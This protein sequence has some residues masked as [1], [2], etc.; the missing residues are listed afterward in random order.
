MKESYVRSGTLEDMDLLTPY[1]HN[2]KNLDYLIASTEFMGM[3]P[4]ALEERF[5]DL[6][7][8]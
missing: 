6:S 3:Y 2:Y 7:V 5:V 1:P 4:C 8:I